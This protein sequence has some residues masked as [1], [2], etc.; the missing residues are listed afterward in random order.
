MIALRSRSRFSSG[1]T[2]ARLALVLG[3]GLGLA[4][5]GFT[6]HQKDAVAEFSRASSAFGATVSS[7]MVE[8]RTTVIEL[9][10]QVLAIDPARIRD[11]DNLDAA[12]SNESVG[13]RVRAARVIQTY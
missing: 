7:Q 12:F 10:T 8:M 13:A 3:G 9:N 2:A 1:L 5:C 11:R 4:A 6:A